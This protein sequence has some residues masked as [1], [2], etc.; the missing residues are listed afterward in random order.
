MGLKS[1]VFSLEIII[2]VS[3][4]LVLFFFYFQKSYYFEENL[5]YEKNFVQAKDLMNILKKVEAKN[6]VEKLTIKNLIQSNVLKEEDLEISVLDLIGSLWFSDY[7]EVARNISQ[8]I[9]EN[10]T[11]KCIRLDV[12]N[13]TIYSSCSKEGK[14]IAASYTLISGYEIGKPV[15]GY[16][17]RAWAKR[18]TKNTTKIIPFYPE[19][20]GWTGNRLEITKN[21]E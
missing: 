9:L 1:I 2:G 17:A 7:R 3:L 14:N 12:F 20:S 16:I 21:F 19:G 8:E 4:I 18:F 13:E 10:I 11:Q 15:S 5:G 6:F